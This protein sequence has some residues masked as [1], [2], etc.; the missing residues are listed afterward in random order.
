M[1][2]SAGLV[3]ALMAGTISRVATLHPNAVPVKVV[4]QAAAP[5]QAPAYTEKD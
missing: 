1:M 4:V 3:L 5:V 2:I